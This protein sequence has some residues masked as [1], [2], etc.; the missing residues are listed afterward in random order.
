MAHKQIRVI[1]P[2]ILAETKKKDTSEGNVLINN[3][4]GTDS[5]LAAH[6]ANLEDNSRDRTDVG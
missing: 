5:K 4:H 6:V 3:D 2:L 1:W